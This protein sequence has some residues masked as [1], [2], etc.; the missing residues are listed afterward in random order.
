MVLKFILFTIPAHKF[1]YIKNRESNE[2]LG[3]LAEAK[4]HSGQDYETVCGLL[5]SIKGKLDDEGGSRA[6]C[7]KL[8]NHGLY[9]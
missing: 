7:G 6:N 1:L 5:D 8:A 2:V 3:F 4:S 9:E